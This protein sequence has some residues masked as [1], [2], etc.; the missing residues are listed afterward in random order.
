MRHATPPSAKK[1]R[2][3]V[4][5]AGPG[6]LAAAILL[7][8]A[9]CASP[10]WSASRASAAAPRPWR[11]TA[12]A[13]T[14]GRRSSS[15]PG[16]GRDL[17]IRRL[18]PPPRGAAGAARPAVPAHLRRRRGTRWPRR[19]SRAGPPGRGPVARRT[20]APCTAFLADNR[21]KLER[22]R[23]CIESPFLGLEGCAEPPRAE[24]PAQHPPL[25]VARRGA[26][27]PTS[28]TRASGSRSRSSRST[29]ACRRSSAR[30]CSPSSPSS[31]TS[32]A[33]STPSA[34]AAR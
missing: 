6:G 33:S 10:S 15:I 30:A 31:S 29:W 13:S 22:F 25:A 19:T 17:R 12:S 34:A 11:R 20:G 4:V 18:R 8:G 1:D 9:G 28:P 27:A 14:S 21:D 26:R 24:A 23:P 16:P 2:V 7:A 32:T 5:G 3:V